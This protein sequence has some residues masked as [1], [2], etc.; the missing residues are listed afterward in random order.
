MS[1]DPSFRHIPQRTLKDGLPNIITT[2]TTTKIQVA[3]PPDRSPTRPRNDVTHTTTLGFAYVNEIGRS[4]FDRKPFKFPAGS[5]IVRERLLPGAS[6]ADQLVVMIKHEK[7]FN[8]KGNGWEF[9][10]ISGDATKIMK[11][12]KDGK[13][14]KCHKQA[15]GNDFV[16]PI[17]K[18]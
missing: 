12:E 18:R 11:R 14:L 1:A 13:C 16:F 10:T 4:A 7:S 17:E 6:N 5:I 15:A 9:L 2:G 3:P 8:R